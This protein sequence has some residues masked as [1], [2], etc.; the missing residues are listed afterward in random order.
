ML[1]SIPTSAKWLSRGAF[2][3]SHL[4][5]EQE[6]VDAVLFRVERKKSAAA[7]KEQDGGVNR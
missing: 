2:S 7:N 1:Q 3:I 4:L 6:R 5:R